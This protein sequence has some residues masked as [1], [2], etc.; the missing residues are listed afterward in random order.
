MK[1]RHLWRVALAAL[2]LSLMLA[3][4]PLSG[5][6]LLPVNAQDG[7]TLELVAQLRGSTYAVHVVGDYAYIGEGPRLVIVDI[8]DPANPTEV[9]RTDVLPSVV[10]DVHVVGDYAYV[11]NDWKGL[12]IISISDKTNPTEVASFDT[13]GHAIGVHVVGDY[14][15]V[16]DEAGGLVILR[17][18]GLRN[19]IYLPIVVKNFSP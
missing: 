3:I 13:A 8:S 2:S 12:Q 19:T 14:A 4:T 1:R 18:F 10:E 9:G 15:Y 16:A 17:I 5:P 11:A 6:P 7:V